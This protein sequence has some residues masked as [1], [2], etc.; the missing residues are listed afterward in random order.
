MREHH[1]DVIAI[2]LQI[3]DIRERYAVDDA[4]LLEE[5]PFGALGRP[6]R[7]RAAL[8]GAVHGLDEALE[9]DW[10]EQV[11]D[12][13]VL[14]ALQRVAC[15]GR[16]EHDRERSGQDAQEREPVE[17]GHVDVEEEQVDLAAVE[18][19]ERL[20]RV[21]APRGVGEVRQPR[22][23]GPE[24]IVRQRLVVDRQAA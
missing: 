10:L 16:G 21:H 15:V 2:G 20:H 12:D 7:V 22:D 23:I 18:P 1:A 6:D 11:V 17:F 5:L 9:C 13:P 19:F 3:A 14:V 24:D 4:V 8:R